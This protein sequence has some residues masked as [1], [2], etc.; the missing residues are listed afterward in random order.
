LTVQGAEVLIE[1]ELA[2]GQLTIGP[3]S[4]RFAPVDRQNHP[5]RLRQHLEVS[6]RWERDPQPGREITIRFPIRGSPRPAN[7][8]WIRAA[9]VAAFATF[10]YVY[11][12]QPAFE[13]LLAQFRSPGEH[14]IEQL[15]IVFDDSALVDAREIALVIRPH[16][17]RSVLAGWDTAPCSCPMYETMISSE[18][19]QL[20][21]RELQLQRDG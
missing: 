9:F 3:G 19:S 2:R 21:K 20:G 17:L 11:A 12:F 18:N 6:D 1:G 4:F 7:L 8:S 15:P 13:E 10:G 14:L 5:E 16:V